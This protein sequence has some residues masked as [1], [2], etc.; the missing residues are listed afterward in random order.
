[1]IRLMLHG[2][3]NNLTLLQIPGFKTVSHL[4]CTMFC[5]WKH[6]TV[7]NMR[8]AEDTDIDSENIITKLS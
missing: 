1:M 4:G 3:H 5:K 8:C 7:K 6:T 2:E